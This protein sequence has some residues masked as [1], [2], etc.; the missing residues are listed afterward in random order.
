MNKDQRRKVRIALMEAGFGIVKV[1][2]LDHHQP[3]VYEETWLR[4]YRGPDK[5]VISWGP[6]TA[7]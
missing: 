5:I 1:T 7:E 4:E 3:G 2:A 6:R